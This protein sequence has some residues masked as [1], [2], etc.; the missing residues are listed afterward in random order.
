[1]FSSCASHYGFLN[2]SA[3]LIKTILVLTTKLSSTAQIA[4]IFGFGELGD[5]GLLEKP[6]LD[7]L[8]KSEAEIK[9]GL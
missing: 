8:V 6:K 2:N 1:M 7:M 9:P 3:S 4:E 5:D